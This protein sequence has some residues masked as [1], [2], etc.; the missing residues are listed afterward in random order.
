[1]FS[2]DDIMGVCTYLKSTPEGVLRKMMV[3]PEMTEVHFR[4]LLKMAKGGPEAEFMDAFES[5]NFGKI[6]LQTPEVKIKE[7]FWV[8]AKKQLT[9]MGLLSINKVREV[10]EVKAA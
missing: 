10:K 5:E 7:H 2:K 8:I 4:L 1:M 3:G 6:K 9:K